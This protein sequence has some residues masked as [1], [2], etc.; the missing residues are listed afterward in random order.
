[1]VIDGVRKLQARMTRFQAQV[2]TKISFLHCD[3]LM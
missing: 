3:F 2:Q 1:M